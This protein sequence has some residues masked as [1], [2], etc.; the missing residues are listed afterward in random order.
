MLEKEKGVQIRFASS[1]GTLES[2][3]GHQ[4]RTITEREICAWLTARGIGHRHAGEVIIV[5]AATN[6]SPSLFVPDILLTKKNKNG[7]NI[8]IETLHNFAPKRGGL[9]TFGAFCKQYGD[10][11]YSILVAKKAN[12]ETIP[13]GVFDARV[14]LEHLDAL[15]K[16]LNLASK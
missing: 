3:A 2:S 11:Y 1:N 10:K 16:K 6:G 9:K 8:V 5:K 7:K 12:L 4:V 14:E 15:E 13:K